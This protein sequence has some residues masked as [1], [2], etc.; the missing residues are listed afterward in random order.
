[1]I[2]DYQF[3][4][5]D[6]NRRDTS[7]DTIKNAN[8]TFVYQFLGAGL[9]AIQNTFVTEDGKQGQCESDDIQIGVSDF[10]VDYDVYYKSTQSPQFQ[11]V[12]NQGIV[13]LVSG[14]L[15]ITEV[16][17]I[18]KIQINKITPNIVSATKKVTIDGK[19]VISL[20]GNSF[21]FTIEN[22]ANHEAILTV[23]DK[24]TGAKNDII[25]PI[26]IKRA[27]I[28]GKLIV[29]PDTVGTDPFTVKFD[30]STTVLN[31]TGDELV[32]FTR[33]FGDGS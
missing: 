3:D 9:Y 19:P 23:E 6:R 21:E 31:D 33:D 5:L 15:I 8:G 25:I 17:T 2:T 13:S 30:A 26:T 32:S 27:D 28:I 18:I 29:T 10:Q 7:V 11:K 24:P 4:I 14:G 16:P 22:A 20:D 1:M 12:D